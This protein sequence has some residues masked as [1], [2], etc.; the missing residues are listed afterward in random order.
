MPNLVDLLRDVEKGCRAVLSVI[1]GIV[2]S[3]DQA[4]SFFNCGVP[5]SE[6]ELMGRY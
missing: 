2:Y 6:A 3:A 4:M 5:Q 1:E